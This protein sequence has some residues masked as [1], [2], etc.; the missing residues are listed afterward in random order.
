MILLILLR[1]NLLQTS[2]LLWNLFSFSQA[3]SDPNWIIAMNKEL[4][5]LE[6]NH[7]WNLCTLH[8]GK[9]TV[10]CKWAYKIK[11]VAN[12]EIERFK[13]RL[14]TKGYTQA[15]GVDYHDAFARVAKIVTVKCILA[16]AA[17]KNWKVHQL[18][19]IDAFLQGDLLEEVYMDLPQGYITSSQSPKLVCKFQKSFY[20]LKQASRQWFAKIT[21][22]LL[23]AGYTQSLADYSLFTL[24]K[25]GL[26]TAVVVYLD[27]ILVTRYDYDQVVLLKGMLDTRC[28][29]KDSGEIKYYLG[30][31]VVRDKAGIFIS[32]RKFILDLLESTQLL[33]AKPLTILLDQHIKLH[34]NALFG[35]LLTDPSLYRSWVGKLLY[36]TLSRPNI[37]YSVQLLS[38]FM[39]QPRQK[40]LEAAIL[41]NLDSRPGFTLSF[42]Q[43][44]CFKWIL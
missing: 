3:A 18:D 10:G 1:R 6:S 34:Y 27:D 16:I 17:A 40:H 30:F 11:Y 39:Q 31:E 32:Q 5:A 21:T 2:L 7:T 8:Q 4:A 33:D 43:Q 19:V 22:T 9:T 26:F 28:R 41:F 29:I 37:S 13:A 14:V 35:D 42:Q 36:L 20:G 25:D 24:K 23:E 12:G 44:S 38:Q 15:E